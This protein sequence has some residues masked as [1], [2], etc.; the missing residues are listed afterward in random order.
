VALVAATAAAAAA[1]PKP[2]AHDRALAGQLGTMVST[3]QLLASKTGS[4]DVLQQGLKNCASLKKNSA[5]AFAAVLVLVPVLMIEIVSRYKGPLTNVRDALAKMHPHAVLFRQWLAAEQQSLN[6]ILQFDSHGKKVDACRAVTV[7]LDKTA[8]AKDIR[9]VVGVDSSVIAKLYKS[10]ASQTTATLTR[11]GP[12]MR[13]F[14][15]TAGLS[16]KTAAAITK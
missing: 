14:L 2:D 6:L 3:F 10:A 12:Q 7:L 11:L 16:A 4:G 1:T 9:A 13:R 15:V 8:T 5:Q